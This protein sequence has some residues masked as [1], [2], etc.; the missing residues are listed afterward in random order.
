MFGK[1]NVAHSST[2]NPLTYSLATLRG[3]GLREVDLT[4]AFSRLIHRKLSQRTSIKWPIEAEELFHTDHFIVSIM[5]Y[6]VQ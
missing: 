6:A 5:P 4:K 3:I 1:Q 2:V